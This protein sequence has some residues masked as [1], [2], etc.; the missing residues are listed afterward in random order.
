MIELSLIEMILMQYSPIIVAI[1]GFITTC[2]KSNSNTKKIIT[3]HINEYTVL[4]EEVKTQVEMKELKQKIDDLTVQNEA[5]AV[6][7]RQIKKEMA[8]ILTVL[9]KQQYEI[10]KN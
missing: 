5:L 7:N 9:R 10:P 8:D 4:K 3:P 1:I 6:E 2:I